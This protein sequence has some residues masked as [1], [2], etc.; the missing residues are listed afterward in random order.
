MAVTHR[1]K[2]RLTVAAT[3]CT[4]EDPPGL[5][6]LNLFPGLSHLF[7]IGPAQPPSLCN[8]PTDPKTRDVRRPRRLCRAN[9]HSP[10]AHRPR[11]GSRCPGLDWALL[12][13]SAR[14]GAAGSPQHWPPPCR[15]L[16]TRQG[17]DASQEP[18]ST[19]EETGRILTPVRLR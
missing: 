15:L 18:R 5:A 2:D 7:P 11:P 6:G 19:P 12:L 3:W 1:A 16:P 4:A 10:P 13:P 9:E 8:P 14:A 17:T